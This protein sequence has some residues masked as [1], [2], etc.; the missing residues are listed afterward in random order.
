[1]KNSVKEATNSVLRFCH[2]RRKEW[3]DEESKDAILGKNKVRH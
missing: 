3:F 2:K 1:M